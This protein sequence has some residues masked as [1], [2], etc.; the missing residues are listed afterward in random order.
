MPEKCTAT[1]SRK[2]LRRKNL[3]SRKEP[4]AI[5]PAGQ[6]SEFPDNRTVL[7]MLR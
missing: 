6:M 3:A 2:S 7:Q 4:S 5:R 1:R